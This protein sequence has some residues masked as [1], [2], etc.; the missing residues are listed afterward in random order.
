MANEKVAV[1][2]DFNNWDLNA[3]QLKITKG[4]W[5]TTL[6]FKPETEVKFRYFIDDEKWSNDDTAD[7]SVG[8]IY[9]TEDS[10]IKLGK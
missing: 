9:G 10:I 1:V 8:N 4:A 3:N 2:G 5:Q 7:G 6:R